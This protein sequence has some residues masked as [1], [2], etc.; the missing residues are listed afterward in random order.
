MVRFMVI[1]FKLIVASA[2]VGFTMQAEILADSAAQKM[3]KPDAQFF[4]C[5]A[6]L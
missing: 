5:G 4:K 2:V 3:T 1:T 6:S